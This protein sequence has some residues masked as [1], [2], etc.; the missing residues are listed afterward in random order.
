[1]LY[2]RV[3]LYAFLAKIAVE[4]EIIVADIKITLLYYTLLMYASAQHIVHSKP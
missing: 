4:Q 1:M 3:L 2:V